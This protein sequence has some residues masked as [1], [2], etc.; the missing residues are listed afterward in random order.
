MPN[1]VASATV[2][3][4][5]RSTDDDDDDDDDDDVGNSEVTSR[6]TPS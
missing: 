4:Y 5:C 6:V 3:A 1:D 2:D